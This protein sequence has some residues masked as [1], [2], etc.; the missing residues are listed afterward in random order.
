MDPAETKSA[1]ENWSTALQTL[2]GHTD[3]ISSVAFSPDG[4]QV[5]SGSDDQTVRLWDAATGV[6]LQTLEGHTNSVYSMAF[7]PDGRQL[8]GLHVSNHWVV[9]GEMNILWLPPD[10]RGTISSTWNRSLIIVQSS[11]EISFFL[12]LGR[13]KSC[14]VE[15]EKFPLLEN[16]RETFTYISFSIAT[17]LATSS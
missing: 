15:L 9:D 13:S 10:Y 5:V 6:A 11:G 4:K 14:S 17:C 3:W 12:L 8:P 1:K 7:S 2:E 16:P